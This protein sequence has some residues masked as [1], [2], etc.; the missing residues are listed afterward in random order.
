MKASK[1]HGERGKPDWAAIEKAAIAGVGYRQLAEMF[2]VSLAAVKKQASRK[3]WLVPARI[4]RRAKELSPPVTGAAEMVTL[5]AGSLAEIGERNALLVAQETARL[6]ERA[7]AERRVDIPAS[8]ND[9]ATANRMIRQSCGME[10]ASAV[11][12]QVNAFQSSMWG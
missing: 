9:L 7:F 3:R 4:M 11:A 8:W 2:G 12:I 5:T 1:R 10:Q 6:V